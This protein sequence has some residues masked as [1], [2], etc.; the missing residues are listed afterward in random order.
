MRRCRRIVSAINRTGATIPNVAT[1]FSGKAVSLPA[2]SVT[3]VEF[4]HAGLDHYF[5]TS[6]QREIDTLDTGRIAGWART[7]QSFKVFPSQASGGA[8]VNPVCRL[9]PTR[10]WQFAFLLRIARRMQSGRA[11]T[12]D[13]S[14]L[15]RLC[16]E[17]PSAFFVALPNTTTGTCPVGTAPVFRLWNQRVDSNHRYTSAGSIKTQMVAAGY[18]AE[19]YGPNAV[20][21]CAPV[22]G[23]AT[24]AFLGGSGAPGGALVSDGASTPAANYQG[25]VTPTANVNVGA[26]A[27]AGEVIAFHQ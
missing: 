11:G 22:A 20:I 7:G 24:V 6:L 15:Q 12:G 14:Q 21:M 17:S 19:G 8:G 27:G 23:T 3:S 18:V 25:F 13:G 4:H 5:I 1:N 16:V 9:H 2:L 26:R 10:A